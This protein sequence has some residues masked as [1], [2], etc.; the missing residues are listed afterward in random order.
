MVKTDV[1]PLPKNL[2]RGQGKGKPR[3]CLVGGACATEPQDGGCI[4]FFFNPVL[5][6]W[7]EGGKGGE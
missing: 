3:T 1:A 2:G 4:T 7:E 6:A 5:V